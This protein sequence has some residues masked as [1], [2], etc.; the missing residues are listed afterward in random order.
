MFT[1]LNLLW[2][3]Y[4]STL[5]LINDHDKYKESQIRMKTQI[6]S[7]YYY[8]YFD[9]RYYSIDSGVNIFAKEDIY[10]GPINSL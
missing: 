9:P 7:I 4:L 3:F 10:F 8:M 2:I 1:L 6:S 5:N